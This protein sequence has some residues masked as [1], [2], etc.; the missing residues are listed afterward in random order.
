MDSGNI[1]F[2]LLIPPPCSCLFLTLCSRVPSGQA[3]G[4][5]QNNKSRRTEQE[6]WI[7]I[8]LRRW[9]EEWWKEKRG[10]LR[11]ERAGRELRKVR[12]A[13]PDSSAPSVVCPWNRSHFTFCH[14][15]KCLQITN[16]VASLG[17]NQRWTS[18][19]S[20]SPP[21]G[22]FLRFFCPTS[23]EGGRAC[24]C[25]GGVDHILHGTVARDADRGFERNLDEQRQ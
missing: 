1:K 7:R 23:A 3:T 5:W 2:C 11:W 6:N 25:R 10:E 18:F 19:C 17:V 13:A 15:T 14:E 24:V 12:L 20:C 8:K 21:M 4:R 16:R 22:Y 9:N